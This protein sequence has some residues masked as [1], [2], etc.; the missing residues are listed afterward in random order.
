MRV[1][2]LLNSGAD[3]EARH[4]KV[5]CM[6]QWLCAVLT[7]VF[8]CRIQ[9]VMSCYRSITLYGHRIEGGALGQGICTLSSP[10]YQ[11][12]MLCD[13][14]TGFEPSQ[15]SCLGSLVGKSIAWRADGR[16]FESHQRQPIFL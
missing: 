11:V 14:Y 4:H 3:V 15:L 13:L 7:V 2:S 10:V 9:V 12:E 8:Y 5:Q 16:G 6:L 1:T